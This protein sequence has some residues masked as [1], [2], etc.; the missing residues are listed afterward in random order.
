MARHRG[1]DSPLVA[2]GGLKDPLWRRCRSS[3]I[4]FDSQ[5]VVHRD[6][7]LLFASEVALRRLDRDVAK[8]KVDLIQFAARE[9]AEAGAGVDHMPMSA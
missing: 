1:D 6:S 7:E 5:S 2:Q 3:G 9:V 8:Q 4:R